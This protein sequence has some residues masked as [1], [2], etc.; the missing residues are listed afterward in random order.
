[1]IIVYWK[2]LFDKNW[3]MKT[4]WWGNERER[5]REKKYNE[6]IASFFCCSKIVGFL[7][8]LI[9]N[10]ISNF[11]QFSTWIMILVIINITNVII[12]ICTYES[13]K[14]REKRE[15]EGKIVKNKDF[16]ATKMKWSKNKITN[17]VNVW[18]ERDKVKLNEG[19]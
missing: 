19:A 14:V 5:E 3:K 2:K 4:K 10:R 11:I 9:W 8:V 17:E 15:R 12:I 16:V 13:R 18:F 6:D 1:M 7:L